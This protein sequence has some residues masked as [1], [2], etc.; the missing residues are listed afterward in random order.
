MYK[1]L[2]K[3][4][5]TI[6]DV[7][8]VID[9]S[10]NA[11]AVAALAVF[12]FGS[13]VSGYA[14]DYYWAGNNGG[15]TADASNWASAGTAC[16]TSFGAGPPGAGDIVHF[17]S[18][19]TS[20]AI[21]TDASLDV[22][23][24]DIQSGYTG[25]IT[26]DS[27]YPITV[28]S[29]NWVQVDGTFVGSD[30]DID[31][32]GRFDLTGT[33]VQGTTANLYVSDTFALNSGAI[34]TKAT[35]TGL[36]TLDGPLSFA[37]HTTPSQD[38][39]QLVITNSTQLTTDLKAT[40]LLSDV[41]GG[42][43][44]TDGYDMEI[45]GTII[46]D[47]SLDVTNGTDGNTTI[48]VGGSWDMDS[49]G[50]FTNTNSTIMFT[51][52][53]ST[54]TITSGG[55][56]FNNVIINDGL[57]AYWKLDETADNARVMDASGYANHG[58]AASFAAGGGPST[59]YLPSAI[60]FKNL[61]SLEFDGADDIVTIP[62]NDIL[63]GQGPLTYSAWIRPQS[64]GENNNGRIVG[65]YS[66]T[67]IYR[68]DFSIA[69]TYALLFRF[70]GSTTLLRQTANNSVA[71]TQWRHVAVTWDGT[72]TATGIH[73][74]VNGAE[75][76]YAT[77][78]DGVSLNDG[79]ALNYYIG[80]T[81][82]I[83]RT[84][85]G[86]IDDLRIYNRVLSSEEIAVLATGNMPATGLG[87]YTLQDDLVIE[88]T[89]TINDGELNT[90]ANRDINVAHSWMNQGGI[91]TANSA[92][93]FFDGTTADG[94]ILPGSQTFYNVDITGSGTWTLQS[95][96][97]VS[98]VFDVSAGV[99]T[100]ATDT[101]IEPI[102]INGNTTITGG[103]FTGQATRFRHAGNLTI[104]SGIYTAPSDFLEITGSFVH[105][106]GTFTNSSGTVVFAG[107]ESQIINTAAGTVFDDVIIN[108]GL[109]LHYRLD[110]AA[111][112]ALDSSGYGNHGT[113]TNSPTTTISTTST[114]DFY[115]PRAMVFNGTSNYVINSAFR[116]PMTD[117]Q[118]VGGPVTITFWNYVS[119]AGLQ[120]NGAFNIGNFPSP[121]I[122][123][124]W[125][126]W[127]NGFVN[128]DYGTG[129]A[130]GR[131]SATYAGHYDKWVHVAVT[132]HGNRSTS[133]EIFFNGVLAATSASSDGPDIPLTGIQIGVYSGV[134]QKGRIDDFRV[135]NRILSD[136]EILNLARGNATGLGTYTLQNDLN[137]D[138]ALKIKSG[139]LDV[140]GSN[141]QINVGGDWENYGSLFTER[142]G[143]V[144][145][146]GNDQ[147]ILTSETFYNL[148]K[149]LT[150]ATAR[151]LTFRQS[152][153]VKISNTLTLQGYDGTSELNLRSSSVGV[154]F[155]IDVPGGAQT[156][157]KVDV[158]D[159]EVL[160]NNIRA[161]GS[162]NSGN[163]DASAAAPHWIFGPLRGA[164][165]TVD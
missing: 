59:T 123:H 108:D 58:T 1:W 118:P 115:N 10:K 145:L 60:N 130:L 138:G 9:L 25:T 133:K 103:T 78:T 143:T 79:A 75:A 73:I 30:A 50:A 124:T 48:K 154:R 27:G 119:A 62:D 147:Y 132:S 142:S 105:S 15:S 114:I 90:G 165:M 68:P 3:I 40:S 19:C 156:V 82:T 14:A 139:I 159:S 33:F 92:D 52:T 125:N 96:A 151:T 98:G 39:G 161:K 102:S 34:F 163:T 55:F 134:F 101:N 77:T 164:V 110:E 36:L 13:A 26:Q 5:K 17:T 140:S 47:K 63:D 76:T 4:W 72:T 153:T 94:L 7:K 67:G 35:G 111:T 127:I 18:D 41:S 21:I 32:N 64:L 80:N 120:S 71:F 56:S 81:T 44:T 46:I 51:G 2:N 12:I 53:T 146:D 66:G 144:V 87:T 16:G 99:L 148:S 121:N 137:I 157:Y 8:G 109:M 84:F 113:W 97:P 29:D 37:D 107:T 160:S 45:S 42:A 126:P 83:D 23:G 152:S 93:V 117:D 91:F 135:Y 70:D 31:I 129:G 49:G 104:S 155:N 95:Y 106:G 65:K 38:L 162:V 11:F 89:L 28:G 150:S 131:V 69:A 158:K 128:W 141:R 61:Y 57:V 54:L 20:D 74:Y 22:S 6:I 100:H 85:D 88:G 112:P 136:A 86:H 43:L 24:V 116:W 122:F 149:T